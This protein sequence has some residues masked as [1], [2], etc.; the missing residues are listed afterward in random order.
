MVA[1]DLVAVIRLI[2]EYGARI[3]EQQCDAFAALFGEDGVLA[4]GERRVQGPAELAE[5]ARTSP[6][7]VHLPGLPHLAGDDAVTPWTFVNRDTGALVCGHYRDV[8][9]RGD[10]GRLL[11]ARR[12]VDIAARVER[13]A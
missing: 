11:F 7:G 6:R 10:D 1:H 4:V 2:A 12:D 13:P 9:R 8:L 5:F 3:D